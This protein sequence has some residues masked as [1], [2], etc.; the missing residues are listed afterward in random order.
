MVML[1]LLAWS[2]ATVRADLVGTI[3]LAA[4]GGGHLWWVVRSE[5]AD[6]TKPAAGAPT[7]ALMH[8]AEDEPAPSARLVMRLPAEP[9]A[10]A[11]EGPRVVVVTRSEPSPKGFIVTMFAAKNEAIGHWYTLPRGGPIVIPALPIEGDVRGLA[12]ADDT[13]GALVRLRRADPR[14]PERFWFGT[15]ACE[16]GPDG[17]W[18]ERAL[19]EVELA[20]RVQLFARGGSFAV[21]GSRDGALVLSTLSLSDGRWSGDPLLRMDPELPLRAVVGAFELGGRTV[22]AERVPIEGQATRI[23][24]GLVRERSVRRWADFVEPARPWG[25]G[26]FGSQAVLLELN[27]RGDATTRLLGFTAE[28]PAE[29]VELR[30]PGFASGS[31]IHLPIIGVLSVALVLS[32]IIFGSDAYLDR[33]TTHRAG[34]G[35]EPGR[36]FRGAPLAARATAMLVDMLPGLVAVWFIFR[37]SP[38][39]LLR[40]PAFQADL[41]ACLP[42]LFV[43]GAG[44]A[45]ASVGDVCFGRSM[46]K[47]TV[48]L[49]IV[50]PTGQPAAVGRR[51]LRALAS[52]VVV[53]SPLVMILALLNPRGDGPAEMLTGTA[54]VDESELDGAPPPPDDE[55]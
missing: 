11:S 54:V 35:V 15:I 49:R 53:A 27:E 39:D 23:R 29:V 26:P 51:I 30:S 36:R 24:V 19:P 55:M 48:G 40:I 22:V 1:A 31:W 32:A 37:G 52:I 9:L 33:R 12:I 44:W 4:S 13:L 10:L 8:H 28:S 7:F 45:V 2:A 18:A 17:G 41:A 34:S 6:G 47:R 25:L 16:S 21:L 42:A 46:G 38:L 3:P 50:T 20:E 5:A 14:A 43:F